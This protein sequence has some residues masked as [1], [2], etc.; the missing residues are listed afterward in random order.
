V[1]AAV[2]HLVGPGWG[3]ELGAGMALGPQ[4]VNLT[5]QNTG[6]EALVRGL[7]AHE[8]AGG[9]RVLVEAAGT[10]WSAVDERVLAFAGEDL[11]LAESFL[12]DV[13]YRVWVRRGDGSARL[14][15]D[16]EFEIA[17]PPWPPAQI[18]HPLVR[19]HDP[20]LLWP[21]VGN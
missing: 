6:V 7:A 2:L 15:L 1:T 9:G 19:T 11:L 10:T 14:A 8:A 13:R 12:R 21:V 16:A 20:A 3:S 4:R 17:P 18:A 5:Y